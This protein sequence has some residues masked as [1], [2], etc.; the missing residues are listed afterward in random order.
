MHVCPIFVNSRNTIEQ[1]VAEAERIGLAE[2]ACVYRV[3]A[4][5]GWVP[6]FVAAVRE[7]E[8]HT[9]I[10]LCCAVEARIMDTYGNLDLPADLDGVEAIYAAGQQAPSPDGPLDQCSARE[11][12]EAGE[13]DPQMVLRWI[14][15]GTAAAA[16]RHEHVAIAS[17]FGVLP[18]LGLAEGDVS[19]DLIDSLAIAAAESDARIVLDERRKRPAARTLRPFLRH[20]VPLMFGGGSYD[21][22]AIGRID[23]GSG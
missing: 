23:S 4:G 2:L 16:H 1:N 17:L 5:T 21:C 18:R 7:A 22:E 3:R 19:L 12:I 6:A 10:A 8:E 13:L 9:S 20:G 11:R 15:D 14:V